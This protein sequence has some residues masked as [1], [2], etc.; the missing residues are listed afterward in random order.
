[1]LLLCASSVVNAQRKDSAHV[2]IDSTAYYDDLFSDM[3]S[4]LDS[5]LSPRT[6]VLAE[7]GISQAFFNYVQPGDYDLE[8]RRKTTYT[9]SFGY[10]HKSGF[11][12]SASATIVNDGE[13]LNAFQYLATA[14]YDYLDSRDFGAGGSYSHYFTRKNLPFYTTPLQN[15]L[16]AYFSWKRW[17]VR[18]ALLVS[19]GWGSRSA[20]EEREAYIISLRLRPDG[21]TRIRTDEKVS[22]F[23]TAL[24]LRHDFYFLNAGLKASALRLTPQLVFTAGTQKFG[25]NQNANTYGTTRATNINELVATENQYLDDQLYFQPLSIAA[26]VKL[27]WTWKFF[28]LQPQY[29]A[30]YYFPAG[31]KGF[32]GIFRFNAGLIF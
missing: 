7:V 22:D 28:L 10:Y 32:L 12:A 25:F 29:V 8:A 11:G 31:S 2:F 9:P 27:E 18:P 17:W 3:E 24:S 26:S 5:V 20:Y 13:K 1:M 16:S 19:Y 15:E 21:F 4:F 23:S 6:F 14:S 30:N